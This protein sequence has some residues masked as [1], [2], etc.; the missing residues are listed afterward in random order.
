MVVLAGALALPGCKKKAPVDAL[1]P[2]P[3]LPSVDDQLQLVMI[4]P[5][6]VPAMT[7]TPAQVVGHGF[8][9]GAEVQVGDTWISGVTVD[10]ENLI[11]LSIPALPDGRYDLSVQNLDGT[12]RTLYAA[13]GV[14]SA[15]SAGG[16]SVARS[17]APVKVYFELDSNGLSS[18]A[19]H[20]LD[21][22]VSCW[23]DDGRSLQIAGHADERGTTDYN[24]ALGQRRANA[25]RAHLSKAGLPLHQMRTVS[26][27]EEQPEDR[28]SNETAWAA[29]RR[30]EVAAD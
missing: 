24:L 4:T 13:I 17:C 5:S 10:S 29:N 22:E 1:A 18:D 25:V 23:L 11:T 2:G 9:S 26:Y 14:G 8:A 21:G 6:D 27:G 12:S 16:A 15:G 30:V 20:A 3:Q 28:S 7:V 19:A